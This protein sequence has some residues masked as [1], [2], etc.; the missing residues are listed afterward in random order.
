M[1]KLGKVDNVLNTQIQHKNRSLSNADHDFEITSET[2]GHLINVAGRQRMLS[3]RI[4]LNIFLS[5]SGHEQALET[6]RADLKLFRESHH[7]LVIGNAEMPGLFF[8]NLKAIYHGELNGH[9]RNLEFIN[10]A[11]QALDAHQNGYR[12]AQGFLDDLGLMAMPIVILLNQI[13]MVYEVESKN[14]AIL[15]LKKHHDLLNDIQNIAKQAKFV[16]VNAQISAARA[17]VV[18]REFAVVATELTKITEKIDTLV[19][20]ALADS[21]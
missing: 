2:F 12:T 17:G 3:Q 18:G 5:R 11:E 16:A 6:A 20:V 15:E 9:K 4:I 13:T 7:D 21:N 1:T 10:M 14:F 8:E 19:R